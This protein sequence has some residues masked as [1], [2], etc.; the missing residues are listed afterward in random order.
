MYDEKYKW[1]KI[2]NSSSHFLKTFVRVEKKAA[3]IVKNH[4]NYAERITFYTWDI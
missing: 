3:T 1:P 2:S 4:E